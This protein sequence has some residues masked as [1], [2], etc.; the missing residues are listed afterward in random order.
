[1]GEQLELLALLLGALLAYGIKRI[2]DRGVMTLLT[3]LL[4]RCH[5]FP[6]VKRVSLMFDTPKSGADTLG[7]TPRDTPRDTYSEEVLGDGAL[8]IGK[9][10][11]QVIR[12]PQMVQF[13]ADHVDQAHA[14]P[15]PQERATSAQ[16]Q[17]W[18]RLQRADGWTRAQILTEGQTV[19]G[20]S[21]ATMTR[22]Y[23]EVMA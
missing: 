23:R 18:I 7:D 19:F 22:R 5:L 6:L 20:V 11:D 4:R 1:M 3:P 16:I 10:R 15:R 13:G 2:I 21:E 17:S 9:S 12:V 8:I 14:V